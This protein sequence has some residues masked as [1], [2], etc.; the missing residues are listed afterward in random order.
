MM[1]SSLSYCAKRIERHYS[2]VLETD[3]TSVRSLGTHTAA[4]RAAARS[5]GAEFDVEDGIRVVLCLP[6][7]GL[8]TPGMVKQRILDQFG[9]NFLE[10]TIN[11]ALEM[12]SRRGEIQKSSDGRFSRNCS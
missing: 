9:F 8:L 4:G 1:P 2:L 6:T 11:I 10:D 3:S 5:T 12:L 7:G